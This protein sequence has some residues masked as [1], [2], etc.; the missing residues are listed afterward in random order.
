MASSTVSQPFFNFLA[1][2][3]QE[4]THRVIQVVAADHGG[5][6]KCPWSAAEMKGNYTCSSLLLF[7]TMQS[8]YMYVIVCD[9]RF[10][11]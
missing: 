9:V 4:A 6:D 8:S 1:N 3:N 11:F 2:A 7:R 10:I 5:T